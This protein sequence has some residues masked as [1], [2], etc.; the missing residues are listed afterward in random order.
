MKRSDFPDDRAIVDLLQEHASTRIDARA[1]ER[2][3]TRL[4]LS[5]VDPPEPL[6]PQGLGSAATQPASVV[7]RLLRGLGAGTAASALVFAAWSWSRPRDPVSPRP[8]ASAVLQRAVAAPIATQ[9]PPELK[10]ADSSGSVA[11]APPTKASSAARSAPSPDQERSLL[12]RAR[13]AL[14]A[15]ELTQAQQKLSSHRALYPRS[16]LAEE[17]SALQIQV[18]QASGQTLAAQRQLNEFHR[19]YPKSLFGP[20][21]GA[22]SANGE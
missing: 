22:P 16:G 3:L 18:L 17:R 1:R 19:R 2:V 10:P 11:P 15:G 7:L 4:S 8:S 20:A 13:T 5:L 12:E 21:L 6:E 14:L 9:A